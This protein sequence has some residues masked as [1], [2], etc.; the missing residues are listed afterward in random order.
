VEAVFMAKSKKE[1]IVE[2]ANDIGVPKTFTEML[3]WIVHFAF[4]L[5]D[6]PVLLEC[7]KRKKALLIKFKGSA[8]LNTVK[9]EPFE[10]EIAS[11]LGRNVNS[12]RRSLERL[13]KMHKV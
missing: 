6:E 2:A 10:Y 3:G 12:I 8:Y 1:L 11:K 7:Q 13:R 9:I 4:R 5:W